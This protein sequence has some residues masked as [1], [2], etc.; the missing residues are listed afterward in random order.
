MSTL[1][2][3]DDYFHPRPPGE[4]FWNEASWFSFMV[5][6]RDLS[7]FVYLYHRPNIGYTVGGIAA[8]DPTGAEN[9][10][11]LVYDWGE[12]YQTPDDAEMFDF[13][14]GNGL[15]VQLVEPLSH[16][17]FCY[18]GQ[19]AFNADVALDLEFIA[20]RP[21][22]DAGFPD[23]LDEWGKGHYDQ[24]GRMTGTLALDGEVID[25]DCVAQRDRSWGV[26]DIVNNP[27]GQMIWAVGE[28]SSFHAL[29]VSFRKPQQDPVIGTA[30]DIIIGY[31]LRDGRYG[32][33]TLAPGN[34]IAVT[35][36]DATGR[37]VT[38]R[39]DATD[40][41]GRHLHAT[42]RVRNMLNW[43]GYSWLTTFWSLVEW[44]LDGHIA[45]GEGQDYWPLHHSRTFLRSRAASSI[46]GSSSPT[47]TGE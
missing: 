41:L 26:R 12:G 43:Q 9:Y 23:G 7:G 38:Y 1:T 15:T 6:E 5:P 10:D 35:E 27:R 45:L 25:I 24:L 34:T 19:T 11:C 4:P 2:A 14:L 32:D 22:H 42:G 47:H 31:Y 40:S 33:L 28:Q 16:Y 8:W 36:R 21:P 37:P 17:R 3:Q 13:T 46:A 44:Q 39:I 29:A 18:R 30:E 20:D